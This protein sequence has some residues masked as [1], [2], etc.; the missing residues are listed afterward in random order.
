MPDD[1][2]RSSLHLVPRMTRVS[3]SPQ[4]FIEPGT[5]GMLFPIPRQG[6]MIFVLFPDVTEQEF[7]ETL[8]SAMPSYV[9]ELRSSPRFD[10]GNLNRHLVFQT[11]DHQHTTYLDLTSSV[12]GEFDSETLVNKF[13]ELFLTS[14]LNLD[15]PMIFLLN[16]IESDEHLMRRILETV[17]LSGAEP[18]HV[19]EIPRFERSSAAYTLA[20]L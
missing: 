2:A 4:D 7:K 16:R 1:K 13:R 19:F 20:V 11:F 12:H 9:I 10:I 8:K 17:T 3:L 5:Q 14:K 15:R 6:V 18:K